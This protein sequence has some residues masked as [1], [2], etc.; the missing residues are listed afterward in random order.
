MTDPEQMQ[1]V[2]EDIACLTCIAERLNAIT[3]ALD[4]LQEIPWPGATKAQQ[5]RI[6]LEL[7][8]I[9]LDKEHL[10]EMF[11]EARTAYC[12]DVLGFEVEDPRR[13]GDDSS[14]ETT[15]KSI[16]RMKEER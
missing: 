16:R 6:A 5:A 11:V 2:A 12:K 15:L 14:T 13:V 3:D 1:S 4:V 10:S 9:I 7:R 8:H